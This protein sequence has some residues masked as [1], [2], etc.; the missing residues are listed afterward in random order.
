MAKRI[1]TLTVDL[2]DADGSH[3]VCELEV[4]EGL[5]PNRLGLL[6]GLA[7]KVISDSSEVTAHN[8]SKKYGQSEADVLRSARQSAFEG[9]VRKI[10]MFIKRT[11]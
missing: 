3:P 8:I 5:P 2:V 7:M 11:E 1:L 9:S 6:Y 10:E 4:S